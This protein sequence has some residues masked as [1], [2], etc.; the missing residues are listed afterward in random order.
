M[1]S[2]DQNADIFQNPE[3]SCMS[4]EAGSMNF[5]SDK[6]RHGVPHGMTYAEFFQSTHE[7][8]TCLH[9]HLYSDIL[10]LADEIFEGR[11][12]HRGP[13]LDPERVSHIFELFTSACCSVPP[14]ISPLAHHHVAV[15]LL[16]RFYPTEMKEICKYHKYQIKTG[17][18]GDGA[19]H[20]YP[21]SNKR[22]RDSIEAENAQD[23]KATKI[24][25]NKI[26]PIQSS[27]DEEN[28][29][30]VPTYNRALD[31]VL[32]LPNPIETVKDL[33]LIPNV[34][35]YAQTVNND[36]IPCSQTVNNDV[37]T[38]SQPVNNNAVNPDHNIIVVNPGT[39]VT[40]EQQNAPSV[41]NVPTAIPVLSVEEQETLNN[42]EMSD[43]NIVELLHK[44]DDKNFKITFFAEI[45]GNYK[46]TLTKLRE[47]TNLTPPPTVE[48][49]GELFK[50]TTINLRQFRAVQNHL[51]K[52][53][54]P[55]QTL[56][57]INERPKKYLL[58]GI[59]TSTPPEDVVQFLQEKGINA[60]SAAYL[61]D[62]RTKRP[63]PL[64]MATCRPSPSLEKIMEIT[65]FNY[66]TISVEEFKP[67]PVKQCYRCEGYGHHSFTCT[68]PYR[69][70]KCAKEHSTKD[71]T[72]DFVQCCNCGGDHTATWR[73]CPSNP[74]N[75]KKNKRAV[76]LNY[77]T[78][79]PTTSRYS[80][81]TTSR[82]QRPTKNM[83]NYVPAPIPVKNRWKDLANYLDEC[84]TRDQIAEDTEL[85]RR[86]QEV[87]KGTKQKETPPVTEKTK[88]TEPK[89]TSSGDLDKRR[90]PRPNQRTRRTQARREQ[91]KL[92][93]SQPTDPDMECEIVNNVHS[94][95]PDNE[96]DRRE[97]LS[98]DSHNQTSP[99]AQPAKNP[100]SNSN[101]DFSSLLQEIGKIFD[102]NK[103]V[104][105]IFECIELFK[106]KPFVNALFEV[107]IKISAHWNASN[108]YGQ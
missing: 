85:A 29:V 50:I 67:P 78:P 51:K 41:S 48:L 45:K 34:F 102:I 28:T 72:S 6:I 9:Y 108:N 59:P 26:T 107:F 5:A 7:L 71:C 100:H 89:T 61:R 58:R 52:E 40:V 68:L 17:L 77:K 24:R 4:R 83:Q 37:I 1:A 81:A 60:L 74:L 18:D 35:P 66:L 8:D 98:Q 63:M 56:D 16:H 73:G 54:I 30:T 13:L 15:E 90:P 101:T 70:G 49:T 84:A 31:E 21:I 103:Y 38:C 23:S 80:Q 64:F 91:E 53:K 94:Y 11:L 43:D 95:T 99:A 75:K 44:D 92:N 27:E 62:R 69:C 82:T 97:N 19:I 33:N 10:R 79:N 93:E 55:F 106:N 96:C 105:L 86:R 87:N 46:I 36:V 76:P 39:S 20:L 57:P 2:N 47:E 3:I 25:D 12:P 104:T 65:S 22:T 88:Q 14:N 32:I 42:V